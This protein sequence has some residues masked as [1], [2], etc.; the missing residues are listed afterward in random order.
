MRYDR[1]VKG[2]FNTRPNRFIAKVEASG[3]EETVHVKNTGRCKELLIPGATVYLSVSDNPSRKTAY[4]LI[5]VEKKREGRAPLIINIDSAAPNEAV[6][7]WLKGSGLFGRDA[8]FRREVTCGSSRF[9]FQITEGDKISYLE[10]KGVTLESDGVLM[11]PDAPTERGVKHLSELCELKRQGFGAY[12]LFVIQMNEAEYFTPNS[13][14]HKAFADALRAAKAAG[15][16]ILAFDC[17]VS[18][19]EMT[20]NSPVEVKL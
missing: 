12:V 11:F 4:D 14:T 16:E 9:D 2:F 13:L 3:R 17:N 1:V 10:V 7:E 6:A 8:I 5:A 19:N 20:I 18:E 15:V